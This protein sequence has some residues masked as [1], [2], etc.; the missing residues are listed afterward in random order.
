MNKTEYIHK[1]GN[2]YNI[3]NICKIKIDGVWCDGIIYR[4]VNGNGDTYVRK[5]EDFE[6]SFKLIESKQRLEKYS[7][8]FD[9]KDNE[10]VGGV[11]DP[12]NWGKRMIDDVPKQETL[13]EAKQRIL[14]SNY[15]T[16]N[17][18]DIFEMGVNW[19][20]ERMYSEEDLAEVYFQGWITRER[21][22]DLSP[23]I[24]YPKGLDYEGKQ[25]YAFKKWFEKFRI[26]KN[27]KNN[28]K[29]I[30]TSSQQ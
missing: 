5:I 7:E 13:E 11:F 16:K 12:S 14:A 20:A 1:N 26:N 3:I 30:K 23:D 9:N 25:D 6:N 17:D 22:D 18:A 10:F 29:K 24:I 15:M 27:G 21:F 28:T 2:K 8:R 19:Q 4:D